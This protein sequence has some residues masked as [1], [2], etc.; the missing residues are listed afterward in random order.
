[1]RVGAAEALELDDLGDY[2]GFGDGWMLYPDE[3]GIWT[4]GSRS[5]LALTIDGGRDADYFLTLAIGS[6]CVGKEASLRVEALVNGERTSVRDFS[7]GDPEWR[8]EL[9]WPLPADGSV[10][11][12]FVIEEPSSP[13]ELGWSDDDRRLGIRLETITLEEIDRSVRLGEVVAFKEGSGSER[14]LGEGW[15]VLE[16]TGVWTDGPHASL[17]F[18]PTPAPV[19]DLELVLEGDPFVFPDHQELTTEVFARGE[20]LGAR[21]FR[22]RRG[23]RL[24]RRRHPPLSVVVPATARDES[25]RVALELRL[26]EPARPVDLGVSSDERSLG[27]HLQSLTVRDG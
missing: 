23:A 14:L 11:L 2:S 15:S 13:R 1:L 9:P 5:E 10:D 16:P 21:T 3:T 4:E 25:G 7:Y 18:R 8:I 27:F 6:I 22:H 17:V 24:L 19:G 20:R 12:A 26:G